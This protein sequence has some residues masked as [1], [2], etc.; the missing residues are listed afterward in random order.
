[1]SRLTAHHPLQAI[2]FDMDGTLWNATQ[3]YAK[4]W[5]ETLA[6]YGILTHFKGED[7]TPYMGLAIDQIMKAL[8]PAN[9]NL[10]TEEFLGRLA[11][12]EQRRMPELGGVL[13]E[14]VKQGLEALSRRYAVMLLSNCAK[15][16]L[17]NFMAYSSTAQWITDSL[18]YGERPVPKG[19]NLR[20]LLEKNHL[21]RGV[22]VG[23]TQAD[24][25]QTHAAG[26]PFAFV[27]YGFGHC[28]DAEWQF[29]SFGQLTDFFLSESLQVS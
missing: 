1:M 24:A 10:D 13:Y 23:D 21:L 29:D 14:G 17:R 16:G 15:S 22:Y 4:I 28:C 2:V 18:T 26:M 20:Y 5:N 3:S 11:R 8:L 27:T 12:V 7:L 9:L 25:N 6:H 19:E